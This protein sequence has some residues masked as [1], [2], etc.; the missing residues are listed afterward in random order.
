VDLRAL[1][2]AYQAADDPA[3]AGPR[4]GIAASCTADPILPYLGPALAG[5]LGDRIPATTA[6]AAGA[7][8]AATGYGRP[9]SR[10]P[11]PTSPSLAGRPDNTSQVTQQDVV[12][13]G[14]AEHAQQAGR[15]VG[16][17][18]DH[19]SG[20]GVGGAD[21]DAEGGGELGES[22]VSAQVHQTDQGTLVRREPAA[23]V[24]LAG[25]DEHGA[26]LDQGMGQV[27]CAGL[28][29]NRAPGTVS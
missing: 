19:R 17:Q 12:G 20:V 13:V 11:S 27:E 21:G 9:R 25:G 6:P 10:R 8:T 22:V 4:I 3:P 29:T 24:T 15:A 18:A 16:E 1:R 7:G 26:A 28:E 14:F 2:A 23:A 5:T